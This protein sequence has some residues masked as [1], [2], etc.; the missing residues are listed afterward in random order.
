[1]LTSANGLQPA[2]IHYSTSSLL[3]GSDV[4]AVLPTGFGKSFIFQLFVL[5]CERE[6]LRPVSVI[7]IC[8]LKRIVGDQIGEANAIGISACSMADVS[9]EDLSLGN[10]QLI[11]GSAEVVMDK[12]RLNILKDS[13]LPLHNKLAAIVVDECHTLETWTGKRYLKYTHCFFDGVGC[14]SK[15]EHFITDL[16]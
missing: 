10:F 7:V 2:L 15:L 11:F 3:D 14:S 8:P 12:E 5:S 9:L 16:K 13:N 1:M 6:R 4:L